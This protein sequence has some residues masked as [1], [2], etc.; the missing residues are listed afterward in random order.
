MFV[1]SQKKFGHLRIP[2]IGC[3]NIWGN[4]YYPLIYSKYFAIAYV[5]V[6]YENCWWLKNWISQERQF[7]EHLT[8][9]WFNIRQ[10]FEKPGKKALMQYFRN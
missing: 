2:R 7:I 10:P 5:I 1:I 4:C 9:H 6:R 8:I 3:Q